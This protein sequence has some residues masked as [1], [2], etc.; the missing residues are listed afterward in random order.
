[1]C[2]HGGFLTC[3][4]RYQPGTLQ[5][6][7]WENAMTIDSKSW[8]YVKTSTAN[9]YLTNRDIIKTLVQTVR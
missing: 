8:G 5:T 1:M 6:R 9:D 4:D 3:Q 7:K 2:N